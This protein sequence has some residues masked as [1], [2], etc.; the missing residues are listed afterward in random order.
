MPCWIGNSRQQRH[1]HTN[2]RQSLHSAL[3]NKLDFADR[4]MLLTNQPL[5]PV[6]KKSLRRDMTHPLF[7]DLIFP[8]W[9]L[10]EREMGLL[11]HLVTPS[12]LCYR[13]FGCRGMGVTMHQHTNFA[14]NCPLSCCVAISISRT[15]CRNHSCGLVVLF[16]VGLCSSSWTSRCWWRY[17]LTNKFFMENMWMINL[18]HRLMSTRNADVSEETMIIH[19]EIMII[20]SLV[21]VNNF[22]MENMWVSTEC[23]CLGRNLV[24]DQTHPLLDVDTEC[25]CHNWNKKWDPEL[26]SSDV[27]FSSNSEIWLTVTR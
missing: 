20:H 13:V 7:I 21:L 26:L 17:S 5:W 23:K 24:D 9:C 14:F 2:W 11:S 18:I 15:W 25:R 6:L 4:A 8:F 12:L 1:S 10:V 3:W 22:R 27:E 16:N 19:E